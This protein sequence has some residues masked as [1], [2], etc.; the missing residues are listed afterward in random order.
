MLFGFPASIMNS[1]NGTC[2]VPFQVN[3]SFKE[4]YL[5]FCCSLFFM[6]CSNMNAWIMRVQKDTVQEN[7]R[8]ISLRL[9][10]YF[11][12]IL[13][14]MT[15][16]LVIYFIENKTKNFKI[17]GPPNIL[18]FQPFCRLFYLNF[19]SNRDQI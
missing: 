9:N 8:N 5:V 6:I 13:N 4:H 10:T 18:F 12:E 14:G 15:T 11:N 1:S 19:L 17:A 7:E 2:L 3:S 16:F